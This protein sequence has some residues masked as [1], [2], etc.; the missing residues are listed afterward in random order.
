MVSRE[1]ATAGTVFW[2]LL[3]GFLYVWVSMG[4]IAFIQIGLCHGIAKA[5]LA[6]KGTFAGVVRASLL[7]WFVNCLV[8]IPRLGLIAALIAWTAVLMTVLKEVDGL[9]RSRAF[10]V[11]AGVNGLYYLLLLVAQHFER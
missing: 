3:L 11:T 5:F 6:V 8:V 4:T 1:G 2:G 9:S 10:L 7:S